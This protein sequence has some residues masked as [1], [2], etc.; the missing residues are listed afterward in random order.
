MLLFTV[1]CTMGWVLHF[2]FSTPSANENSVI[3]VVE[4]SRKLI[5]VAS[6]AETERN[7]PPAYIAQSLSNDQPADDSEQPFKSRSF[8]AVPPRVVGKT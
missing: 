8:M 7:K 4:S 2:L 3:S 6:P 1:S 5:T